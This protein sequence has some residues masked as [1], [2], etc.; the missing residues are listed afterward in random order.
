M[1]EGRSR[2]DRL[3]GTDRG[4]EAMDM[5][6]EQYRTRRAHLLRAGVLALL[7]LLVAGPPLEAT[8]QVTDPGI[9]QVGVQCR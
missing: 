1:P 7:V 4:Q 3:D 6:E 2:H 9:S 5:A 8:A